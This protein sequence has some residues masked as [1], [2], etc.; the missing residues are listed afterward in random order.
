MS[1][2]VSEPVITPPEIIE[3]GKFTDVVNGKFLVS[4]F[5]DRIRFC[6]PW[7]TWLIWDGKR[8][9]HDNSGEIFRLAKKTVQK[10]Y[11][12]GIATSDYSMKE[13]LLRHALKSES[14]GRLTAMVE[15]AKS[16][17]PIPVLPANLDQDG[18]LF[19]VQNGTVDL[20]TGEL[21]PHNRFDMITK[22][23]PVTYEKDATCPRWLDF[24]NTIFEKNQEVIDFVQRFSGY[25]LTGE[26]SE[27]CFVI[28]YGTGRNGKSKFRE[29]IAYILGDYASA[30]SVDSLLTKDHESAASNDIAKLKGI[31]FAHTSEQEK[32]RRLAEGKIKDLTGRDTVT[33]R[34]LYQEFFDFRPEFKLFMAANHKPLVRGT[35][36]AIWSRIRLLPFNVTISK[37]KMDKN[38]FSKLV[39]EAP[40]ILNWMLEGC[41][42]WQKEGLNEPSEIQTATDEYKQEMDIMAEFFSK[43]CIAEP[44]SSIK[45][46]WLRLV[47][48]AWCEISG[49]KPLSHIALAQAIQ[50]RGFG[51]K[52][53]A[54]GMVYVGLRLHETY[55]TKLHEIEKISGEDFDVGLQVMKVFLRNLSNNSSRENSPKKP[56]EHTEHTENESADIESTKGTN[57]HQELC[58]LCDQPLNGSSE[59][60]PSGKGT[61]HQDCITLN[62]EVILMLREEY[63]RFPVKPGEQ[64]LLISLIKENLNSDVRFENLP[65]RIRDCA[66]ADLLRFKGVVT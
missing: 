21:R 17:L 49:Q 62:R 47:Y 41:L 10:L 51:K 66:I 22:T 11:E 8:W 14:C 35:D 18:M 32:G 2:A 6:F 39:K 45:G 40:G 59:Q 9:A 44:G 20:R 26:T 12:E 63:Q 30:V 3:Y 27:E 34:F 64:E 23:S 31:R 43:H 16:E 38:L 24:L 65:E 55:I 33:A 15:M 13:A 29:M 58:G 19:N 25:V 60:G 46:K 50:E 52:R 42:L 56:T 48:M 53:E 28:G 36:H 57:L 1:E 4:D 61:C 7:K 37:E 54:D 5:G